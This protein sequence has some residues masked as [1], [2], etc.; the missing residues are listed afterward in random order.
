[1]S[2]PPG[3][4]ELMRQWA[5]KNLGDEEC[6]EAPGASHDEYGQETDQL[7]TKE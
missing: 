6:R 2:E 1:M 5:E 4:E 3:D 7:D